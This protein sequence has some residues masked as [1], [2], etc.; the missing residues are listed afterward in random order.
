VNDTTVFLLAAAAVI[1]WLLLC[2]L[3]ALRQ[4]AHP[5]ADA[6]DA[7]RV[8]AGASVMLK[9]RYWCLYPIVER[10]GAEWPRLVE[11][12][13]LVFSV[14]WHYSIPTP[15]DMCEFTEEG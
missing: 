3:V 13:W 2:V 5:W 14:W 11:I 15:S 4:A 12:R 9:C 10:D 1:A 8:D 6:P 7:L